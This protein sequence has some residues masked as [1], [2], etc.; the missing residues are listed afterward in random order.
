MQTNEHKL[1][2]RDGKLRLLASFLRRL[3]ILRRVVWKICSGMIGQSHCG[4]VPLLNRKEAWRWRWR[5]RPIRY[6][7]I[8]LRRW[9]GDDFFNLVRMKPGMPN[10]L[11]SGGQALQVNQPI[12][13]VWTSIPTII[14]N[15]YLCF[16]R[17]DNAL[18]LCRQFFDLVNESVV[19][20]QVSESLSFSAPTPTIQEDDEQRLDK[21]R[22]DGRS[23]C[24][25]QTKSFSD[26]MMHHAS[27]GNYEYASEQLNQSI[28]L[29]MLA[30]IC[31]R[32]AN[33]EHACPPLL[34]LLQ[35]CQS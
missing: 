13:T 4:S 3:V 32:M 20:A 18:N 24:W 14:A 10:N 28:C 21:Y 34:S 15:L 12:P 11:P 26:F 31:C 16:F 6:P 7:V 8:V 25:P 19:F 2:D 9:L 30:T 5:F 27:Y 33:L 23:H 22:Q 1:S 17:F 35:W 29:L